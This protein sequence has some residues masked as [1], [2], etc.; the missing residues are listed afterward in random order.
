MWP[1]N[2]AARHVQSFHGHPACLAHFSMSISPHVAAD[3]H[4]VASHGHPRALSH[5][6]T[7]K[8]P[9]C[10]ATTSHS[11]D[12]NGRPHVATAHSHTDGT[13]SSE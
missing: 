8:F 13:R 10:R 6:R 12:R 2:A 9:R 1:S 5:C 4:V 7:G 11:S 3:S